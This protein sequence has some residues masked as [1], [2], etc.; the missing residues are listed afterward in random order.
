MSDAYVRHVVRAHRWFDKGE[1]HLKWGDDPPRA[2]EIGIDIYAG[3]LN[4]ITSFD[5]QKERERRDEERKRR[6][7]E[8]PSPVWHG[9]HAR[10]R[11]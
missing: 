6:E 7:A 4:A 1:L 8:T 9:R 3:A 2:L 10:L 11:R 5:L